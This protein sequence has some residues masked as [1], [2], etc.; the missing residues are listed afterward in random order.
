[1]T[2]RPATPSDTDRI[3]E[4]LKLSLGD[5]STTKSAHFW[6]WKHL[7]NP[8][9]ASHVLLAEA[10]GI[11]VG[12]RAFMQWRWTDGRREYSALRA[13]D[14]ATHPGY[15]GRGIFKK[16]TLQ[17]IAERTA[18]GDDFIFNTPN[19]QSKP[20]YLK[21][22]WQ[23]VGRLPVALRINRPLALLQRKLGWAAAAWEPAPADVAKERDAFDWSLWEDWAGSPVQGWSTA[24]RPKY[25]GW[26]Y[27]DCPVA[28]YLPLGQR[29]SYLLV[30]HPKVTAL[31]LEFRVVQ[32]HVGPGQVGAAQAALQDLRRQFTPDYTSVAPGRN[33]DWGVSWIRR[34]VGPVLTFRRLT[35]DQAPALTDWQYQLGDMELF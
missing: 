14:T 22:G 20:G 7:D 25:I 31:G 34:E 21:M 9:G 3:V 13:V 27:R 16:L 2:V 32:A 11:L 1:M 29:N 15:R 33:F 26:R 12:V 6:R 24:Y 23:E 5:V 10:D 28:N 4:L 19:S 8:F 18:A 17:L 30:V 35:F